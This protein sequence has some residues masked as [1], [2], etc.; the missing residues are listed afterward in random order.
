MITIAIAV[1]FV[2]GV[3]LG[4]YALIAPRRRSRETFVPDDVESRSLRAT[5][6]WANEAGQEFA[7]LPEPARCELV[8]AVAALYD[9]RAT[10]LLEFALCDPSETVALAAAHALAI[11]GRA[12]IVER[13]L[14]DHPGERAERIAGTLSLLIEPNESE[15]NEVV[16]AG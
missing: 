2:V 3:L 1:L 16:A 12:S 6:D 10:H 14:A 15:R 11:S 9:D 13:V 5:T 7:D 8:F 4:G